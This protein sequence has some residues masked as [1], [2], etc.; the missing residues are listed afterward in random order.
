MNELLFNIL[1]IVIIASLIII[2]RYVV[3]AFGC[4]IESSRYAWVANIIQDAVESAEQTVTQPK[5]GGKKKAMVI[6]TVRRILKEMKIDITED[7]LDS[8]IESAVY[9]MNAAKSNQ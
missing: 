3:P 1:Q 8:L 9:A 5:S 6:D 4:Y 7:Q 2:T